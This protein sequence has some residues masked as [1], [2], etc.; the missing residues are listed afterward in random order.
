M[1]FTTLNSSDFVISTDSVTA[2]AWSSNVPTLTTFFKAVPASATTITQDA[3][4]VNVSQAPV[5]STSASVQFAIAYGNQQGSGS[6][7]APRPRGGAA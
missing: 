7:P 3:F 4:Y 5:G 6:L 2:P 1:S